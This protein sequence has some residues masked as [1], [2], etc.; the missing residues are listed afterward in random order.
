MVHTKA[1]ISK[2]FPFVFQQNKVSFNLILAKGILRGCINFHFISGVLQQIIKIRLPIA[3]S[4]R[5]CNFIAIQIKHIVL[6]YAEKYKIKTHTNCSGITVTPLLSTININII[7]FTFYP[8]AGKQTIANHCACVC[9]CDDATTLP[10]SPPPTPPALRP[11]NQQSTLGCHSMNATNA[12]K[13]R[14]IHNNCTV[15]SAM[16][17]IF[18]IVCGCLHWWTV[19]TATS[20]TYTQCHHHCHRT[21]CRHRLSLLATPTRN[22]RAGSLSRAVR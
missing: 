18:C 14:I 6:L 12:N 22:R 17:N 8:Y 2:P 7:L 13:C 3:S 1:R 10:C 20:Y 9:M 21:N 5:R 16:L 11:L 15:T 19:N 4:W